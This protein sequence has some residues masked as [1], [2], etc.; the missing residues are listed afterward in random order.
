M[1]WQ[2]I[3]HVL[4][5]DIEHRLVGLVTHR[6]ILKSLTNFNGVQ[7]DEDIPVSQIMVRDPISVS[8]EMATIDAVRVMRENNIGALP[9][10]LNGQLVGII[11]ETDFNQLAARLFED[12]AKAIQPDSE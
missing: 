6:S 2:H 1:S 4:V 3:R 8:P 9:V 10:V 11:T 7:E 5:E 12:K